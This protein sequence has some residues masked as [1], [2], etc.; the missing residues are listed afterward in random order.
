MIIFNYDSSIADSRQQRGKKYTKYK[1]K[2]DNDNINK[3]TKN[4]D[5]ENCKLNIF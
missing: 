5:N 1:N 4:N 2:E 3:K